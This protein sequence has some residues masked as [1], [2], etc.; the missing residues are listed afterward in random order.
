MVS[1]AVARTFASRVPRSAVRFVFNVVNALFPRS[2]SAAIAAA[3]AVHAAVGATGATAGVDGDA[4]GSELSSTSGVLDGFA[5]WTAPAV[6]GLGEAS[7]IV[8]V[9]TPFVADTL[10]RAPV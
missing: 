4:D 9:V 7:V 10:T 6:L 2:A 8:M 5:V 1:A 3:S